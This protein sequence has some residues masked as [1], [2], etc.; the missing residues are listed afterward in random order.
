MFDDVPFGVLDADAAKALDVA[1]GK[2]ALLKQVKYNPHAVGEVISNDATLIQNR[3]VSRLYANIF[4]QL[5]QQSMNYNFRN[6]P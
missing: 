3:L 1:E 5:L 4:H 6:F 2:I